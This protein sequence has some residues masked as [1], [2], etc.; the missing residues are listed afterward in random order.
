M[1]AVARGAAAGASMPAHQPAEPS[2]PTV[3][4]RLA[5]LEAA[6]ESLCKAGYKAPQARLRNQNEARLDFIWKCTGVK[7]AGEV[8]APFLLLLACQ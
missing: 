8:Q 3:G 1:S 6:R 2:S 5:Q 7:L 4:S